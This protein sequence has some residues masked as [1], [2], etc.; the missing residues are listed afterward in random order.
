[1]QYKKVPAEVLARMVELERK[2][3]S[4]ER[5]AAEVGIHRVSVTRC[6]NRH[7]RK[8]LE[9]LEARGAATKA[10]Q[11]AQLEWMICEAV[12]GWERSKLN[13]ESEKTVEE[14]IKD[15]QT[16]QVSD[17]VLIKTERASKGQAGNPTFIETAA[18]RMAEVRKILGI[19]AAKD[20][21]ATMKDMLIEAF[22]EAET[23]TPDER[24]SV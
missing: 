5:I 7:N 13:A 14:Q 1:M 11:V 21:K 22:A 18:A 3:W 20:V 12:E 16:G 15:P 19:D 23:H 2:C 6:L 4:H 10:K 8:V 24:P 9:R 17:A